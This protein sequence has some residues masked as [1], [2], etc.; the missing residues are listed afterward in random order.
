MNIIQNI[1]EASTFATVGAG[2]AIGRTAYGIGLV[3]FAGTA[4]VAGLAI[5]G[6]RKSVFG[7]L[8]SLSNCF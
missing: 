1:N 6:M 7:S 4:V 3:G 2:L 5:Y 8:S